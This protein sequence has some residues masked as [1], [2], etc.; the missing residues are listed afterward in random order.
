MSFKIAD[1][2]RSQ[3][4]VAVRQASQTAAQEETNPTRHGAGPVPGRRRGRRPPGLR[5][6]HAALILP[7]RDLGRRIRPGPIEGRR[8]PGH[9]GVAR[10]CKRPARRG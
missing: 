5:L 8:D 3:P 2:F 4:L 7:I 6:P 9:V 1:I 10:K